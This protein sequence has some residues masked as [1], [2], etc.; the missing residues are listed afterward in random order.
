MAFNPQDHYFKMAKKDG[1]L[2]RSAYKL[3]E[4]QKKYKIVR[5]GD[6]VLDLGCAPGSWSQVA[7]ELVGG[8]GLVEGFDLK[9]ITLTAPNGRFFVR[10]V[11]ELKE[12]ELQ[13]FP[14]DVVISDM[15]PNTT[16]IRFTDQA[17]SE[18]LCRKVIELCQ[19][20]LKP[21]GNMV[22]KFFEGGGAKDLEFDVRKLFKQVKHLKPLATRK[23]SKE[24]FVIGIGKKI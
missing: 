11:F 18:D 12:E 14:Y 16:G 4:I 15:A 6:K 7:L 19:K 9:P 8:K 20:L 2:A 23:E 1:Y 21:N 5:S 24:I 13:G 17:R 22:M 3:T 10:D